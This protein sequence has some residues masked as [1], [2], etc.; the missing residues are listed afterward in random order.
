M[1]AYLVFFFI[2]TPCAMVSPA[3]LRYLF[4][5]KSIIGPIA[6]FACMG[7][8]AHKSGGYLCEPAPDS[9]LP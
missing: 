4:L 8:Y 7:W 1:I 3:R 5:G 2:Q 6:G 9:T